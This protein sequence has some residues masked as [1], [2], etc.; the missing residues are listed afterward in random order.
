MENVTTVTLKH[1]CNLAFQVKKKKKEI[2]KWYCRLRAESDAASQT[3]GLF[4]Y[5]PPLQN[6]REASSRQTGQ[7]HRKAPKKWHILQTTKQWAVGVILDLK[8]AFGTDDHSIS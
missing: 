7:I 2:E 8:N 1:I 3:A 6:S 4:L 5:A